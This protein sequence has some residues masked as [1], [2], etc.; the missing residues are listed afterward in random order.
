[1]N[2][3][4]IFQPY[5]V[6]N[7]YLLNQDGEKN[8]V[9]V[10]PGR[11]DLDLLKLV[12]DHNLYISHVLL[13]HSHMNHIHGIPTLMKIYDAQIYSMKSSILG[14]KTNLITE[15]TTFSLPG[16]EV[17]AVPVP[18]HSDDSVIYII[19]NMLFTGDTLMAGYTGQTAGLS[20]QKAM[21]ALIRR[22]IFALE[23]EYLLLPGHGSPSTLSAEKVS[24]LLLKE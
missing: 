14:F 16:M 5:E 21:T 23:G 19:E 13:T 17:H 1:M 15:E 24:N 7:T 2:L 22:K 4:T 10:D 9:L 20:E 6:T 18:G 3:Y 8:A 11:F 12:E